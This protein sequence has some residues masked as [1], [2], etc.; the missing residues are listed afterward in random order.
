MVQAIDD[1]SAGRR[2]ADR[3]G[4][5]E[6]LRRRPAQLVGARSAPSDGAI[7]NEFD[8]LQALAIGLVRDDARRAAPPHGKAAL[9]RHVGPERPRRTT[10]GNNDHFKA[11]EDTAVDLGTALTKQDG[12]RSRARSTPACSRPAGSRRRTTPPARIDAPSSSRS[13]TSSAP[14]SRAGAI[15]TFPR[16]SSGATSI[17]TR[18]RT[19]Q[20]EC[21]TCHAPM[22]AMSGAFAHF[23]FV[24]GSAKYYGPFNVAPKYNINVDRLP[25]RLLAERRLVDELRDRSTRTSASVGT[26]R[27]AARD[28][29]LRRRCSRT[30]TRSRQCMV[31]TAFQ[32]TCR[33]APEAADQAYVDQRDG[34]LRQPADITSGRCSR[35]SRCRTSARDTSESSSCP[36]STFEPWLDNEEACDA[37]VWLVSTLVALFVAPLAPTDAT[38]VSLKNFRELAAFYSAAT[39]RPAD[40]IPRCSRRIRT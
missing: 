22:D 33:R 19:T 30:A 7:D 18:R 5:S 2:R 3:D 29:G 10:E 6:L 8:D 35:R 9:R 16:T 17:A 23:D 20:A 40:A 1:G 34:R 37:R 39:A 12:P 4:R 21:R 38:A 36:L 11:L 28:P 31:K 32:A 14:R 26:G 15:R 13:S 24:D 25:R 27:F